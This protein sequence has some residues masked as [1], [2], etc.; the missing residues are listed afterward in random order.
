VVTLNDLGAD[1]TLPDDDAAAALADLAGVAAWG[2][3]ADL[4]AWCAAV[5]REFPPK[6]FSRIAVV[7]IEAGDELHDIHAAIEAGAARADRE[8]DAG[9]DLVVLGVHSRSATAAT[10]VSVLT[11][12]EPVQVLP[13]GTILS[14]EDWIASAVSVRD[15][16]R[17]AFPFRAETSALLDALSAE[18]DIGAFA[19]AAAFLLRCAQRRLP[20]VL[21]GTPALAAALLANQAQARAGRWW[22][23]ADDSTHPAHRLAL[24]RLGSAPV[25]RNGTDLGDGRLAPLITAT[26]EL[27][28]GLAA[29]LAAGL[30]AD[31]AA[32]PAAPEDLDG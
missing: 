16:R 21:D 17:K 6:P 8:V 30:S 11:S 24:A 2:R 10:L 32:G 31:S 20:V 23:A 15:G 13:R 3:L 18:P 19:A 22:R 14:T 5:Q 25:L 26:L 7:I 9:T 29:D 28:A 4:A 12:T 1:V 27:A